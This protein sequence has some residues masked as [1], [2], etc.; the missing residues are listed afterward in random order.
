MSQL[1]SSG[2]QRIGVTALVLPVNI[3]EWF[4]LG[5]V[6]LIS[7]LSK[8]LSRVLFSTTVQK[9]QFFGAQPSLW[10]SSYLHTWLLE[11]HKF[12]YTHLLSAKW[13]LCFLIHCLGLSQLFFQGAS[14]FLI[15]WLQSPSTSNFGAQNNVFYCFQCFPIYLPLKWWDLMPWS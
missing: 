15:S 1:F 8:G 10:S 4:P 7:F 14:V 2:G 12:D 3:Q 13:C 11:N 6:G 5:L 9:H